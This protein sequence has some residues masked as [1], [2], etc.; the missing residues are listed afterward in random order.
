MF[1]SGELIEIL[2][3]E[4]VPALG[5]T[6]PVAVALACAAAANRRKGI[7]RIKVCVSPNIYKNGMSVGIPGLKEVGLDAAASIGAVA[8]EYSLGL[9]VL[10]NITQDDIQKYRS[11]MEE[12]IVEISVSDNGEK[13]YVEALIETECGSGKCIIKGS[14]S[15]IVFLEENGVVKIQKDFESKSSKSPTEKLMG[16]KIKELVDLISGLEYEDIKFLLEGAVMN[17]K[18]AEY[19]LREKPGMGIG[20]AIKEYMDKGVLADDIY[21]TAQAYTAAASDTRMSGYFMPVMSSA[22]SGNHGLTAILPVVAT[23]ERIGAGEEE[24]ARALAMS[25]AITIF[26]KNYTGRL[27][28][29]CGCGVAA[30]TGA[31]AA[32]AYLLKGDEKQ[33]EGTI[34]NIIADVSG[35]I[36]D[37]AKPG[38]ALKLSTAAGSAVKSALLALQGSIVPSDNGIVA[39]SC[40]E[41][42]ANL[43][44]VSSPGMLETDRVILQVM[45]DKNMCH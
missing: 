19:G 45:V 18:A 43:G 29:L 31:A 14:H 37:G 39:D 27:S 8:G 6:E 33:I 35:M 21:H 20:A 10:N 32:I 4:V 44:K 3:S 24:I 40:E 41:T 23:G 22:G 9:Q 34:K 15:N 12:D 25:H 28:A 36:C 13:L 16:L 11:L 5:C 30:A 38:C 26:I 42:I 1:T 2:K 7:K 17:K